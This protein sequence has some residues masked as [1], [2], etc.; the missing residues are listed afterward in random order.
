MVLG[1]Y[2]LYLSSSS[3][4]PS[5]SLSLS[6]LLGE[7]MGDGLSLLSYASLFFT[8]WVTPAVSW[9]EVTPV[10]LPSSA[11]TPVVSAATPVMPSSAVTHVILV[12]TPV[13]PA[14][15]GGGIMGL[16]H[17]NPCR[18]VD[19]GIIGVVSGFLHRNPWRLVIFVIV[20][21]SVIHSCDVLNG[22]IVGGVVQIC[23][24]LSRPITECY[25]LF[26]LFFEGHGLNTLYH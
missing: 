10:V 18:L 12:A 3:S 21:S 20:I 16:L 24:G 6:S 17:R 14:F 9:S 11:A 8:A 19:G 15:L 13:M 4:S 7:P 23:D 1:W 25:C 26:L 2:G 22:L 5:L